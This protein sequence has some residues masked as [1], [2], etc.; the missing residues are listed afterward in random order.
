MLPIGYCWGRA[1]NLYPMAGLPP[2][3]RRRWR[4]R[5]H[6]PLPPVALP[7]APP[8]PPPLPP[9]P[10]PLLPPVA[11]PPPLLPPVAL[12]PAPP[13]PPSRCRQR[14]RCRLCPAA[15][16]AARCHRCSAR[17][18]RLRSHRRV[19]VHPTGCSCT[20]PGKE[21]RRGD[22]FLNIVATFPFLAIERN[23]VAA[24][25]V[26]SMTYGGGFIHSSGVRAT[27]A[28]IVCRSERI[29]FSTSTSGSSPTT[30][31]SPILSDVHGAQSILQSEHPGGIHGRRAENLHR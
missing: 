4:R 30:R 13:L 3:V 2:A 24:C 16:T 14:R 17:R 7:P 1:P 28:R 29:A 31:R 23:W 26:I 21:P 9:P 18:Q 11:L 19:S 6:L 5:S 8:A 10:A 25:R 15:A 22:N 20:R 12:P 27:P